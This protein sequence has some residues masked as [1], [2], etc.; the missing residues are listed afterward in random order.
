MFRNVAPSGAAR[1]IDQLL[2]GAI[3]EFTARRMFTG[4]LGAVFTVPVGR[5]RLP[6][7]VVLFCGLGSFDRF[8]GEIQQVVAENAIRVL[9]RSRIDEFATILI[10]AGSGLSANATLQN[11]LIGFFRGLKD[12]DPNQR[13]RGFTLCE[14]DPARYAEM[15]AELYRMAATSLFD[16]VEL[17]LRD[18]EIPPAV[19]PVRAS[20]LKR[21]PDPVYATVGR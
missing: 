1:A 15:R 17:S 8:N 10:G 6:A 12:A 9:V 4:D 2:D 20:V 18:V 13:F 5:N 21:G 3:T 14:S 19:A 16:D 7:D 11:L